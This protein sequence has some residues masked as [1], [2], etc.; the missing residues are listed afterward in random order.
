VDEAAE[1][2]ARAPSAAPAWTLVITT[3][4]QLPQD[5]WIAANGSNDGGWQTGGSV[6]LGILSNAG[7]PTDPA[8]VFAPGDHATLK[9]TIVEAGVFGVDGAPVS[10]GDYVAPPAGPGR[11]PRPF[12]LSP[13]GSFYVVFDGYVVN[14]S[15][16]P[17]FPFP[18]GSTLRFMFTFDWAGEGRQIVP[19][20]LWVGVPAGNGTYSYF[21]FLDEGDLMENAKSR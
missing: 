9:P 6:C 17:A 11:S 4:P 1:A 3:A 14:T 8:G 20:V 19:F 16:P 5:V 18:Q 12:T 7:G 13:G 15:E 10:A 2:V 21:P